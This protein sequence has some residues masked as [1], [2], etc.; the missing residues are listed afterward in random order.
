MYV[1]MNGK[2]S[3][4]SETSVDGVNDD[5]STLVRTRATCNDRSNAPAC[6]RVYNKRGRTRNVSTNTK[7]NII[8]YVALSIYLVFDN[9]Q[10]RNGPKSLR[11]IKKRVEIFS[12]V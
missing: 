2:Q 8:G 10:D 6:V 5:V 1:S 7:A 3:I 4:V 11:K 9:E 12:K